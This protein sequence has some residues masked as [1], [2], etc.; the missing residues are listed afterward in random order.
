MINTLE[1]DPALTVFPYAFLY[2]ALLLLSSGLA[3]LAVN[4][5]SRADKSVPQT[6]LM[7]TFLIQLVLLM[8]NLL[9]YRGF[10][11]LQDFFPLLH[12]ALNLISLIWLFWALF[13]IRD[14]GFLNW[15]PAALTSFVLIAG[16]SLG[17]WWLRLP[18]TQDFNHTWMDFIWVGFTLLLISISAVYYYAKY[19]AR[20][21]EA[22]LILIVSALGFAF[23]LVLPS[24]GSMPAAVMLSQ[25]F[26]YPLLVSLACQNNG[27]NQ[28]PTADKQPFEQ[29]ERLRSNVVNAFLDISVQPSQ[30]EVEK[31][32]THSLSLYLM[33]DLLGLL[34]YDSAN[35]QASLKYTYDLIREDHIDNIE[36]SVSQTPALFEQLSQGETLISN[37]ESELKAEKLHL[38]HV[39]GYN[40]IGNLLLY[41]LDTSSSGTKQAILGLSPYTN[42]EWGLKDL[43]RL[44]RLRENL[45][46]VLEKAALLE[47]N[48]HQIDDLR[49]L[50]LQKELL[51][52]DISQNYAQAQTELQ[53]S[54]NDLLETRL[55]W[56]E[57][58]TLWIERQK[59]L[60]AELDT[61]QQTIHD[62][63]DSISEVDDLRM[64][65]R[66]L[67]EAIARSSEETAR[68]KN[69]IQQASLMLQKLTPQDDTEDLEER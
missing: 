15:L 12:R 26:Y 39:S 3:L 55:A 47:Q 2:Y 32:L 22:W 65:K 35:S 13:R 46:K 25:L 7:V 18:P 5:S 21:V 34:K 52:T 60:E 8:V 6:A 37:R 38:M 64:Q 19:R 54:K 40:Q 17:L 66:K 28:S 43:Q 63:K 16:F 10:Q 41:P 48:T 23:Y 50:L 33:A 53:N 36:L 57:E 59:E 44:D 27:K 24:S 30:T 58:V 14:P 1:I 11:P 42:K 9:A 45:N 68:L 51:V 56:T 31:T 29:S 67:E 62:N 20:V 49:S 61:L 4:R 69:A